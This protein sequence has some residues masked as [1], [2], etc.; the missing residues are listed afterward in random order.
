MNYISQQ[1]KRLANR[2]MKKAIEGRG[3]DCPGRIPGIDHPVISAGLRKQ[4]QKNLRI[5]V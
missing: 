3:A 5:G 1:Y 2:M 4:A